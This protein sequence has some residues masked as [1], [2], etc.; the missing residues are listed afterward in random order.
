LSAA[1]LNRYLDQL[2]AATPGVAYLASARENQRSY[3]GEKWG[4]GHGVFT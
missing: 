3:E 1:A 2:S 4:K